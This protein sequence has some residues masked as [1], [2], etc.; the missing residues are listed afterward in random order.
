MC[1]VW[2]WEQ[3]AIIS[4]YSINWL[5]FIPEE[6]LLRGTDW[7]FKCN[8]CYYASRAA[9]PDINFKISTHSQPSQSM[10]PCKH[11]IRPQS[12]SSFPAPYCSS[13]P[14]HSN[15]PCSLP[16]VST[17]YQPAFT[18]RTSGHCL[19]TFITVVFLFHSCNNNNNVHTVHFVQF[20]IYTN[21]C[22]THT[23]T[24]THIYISV[25]FCKHSYIHITLSNS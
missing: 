24:H 18:I 16:N 20:I 25:I 2:I 11:K 13:S 4:V 3:T 7:V 17:C 14:F 5:V 22:T 6:C 12:S 9:L 23:H 19:G 10:P 15:F 1:F 8:L 21:K